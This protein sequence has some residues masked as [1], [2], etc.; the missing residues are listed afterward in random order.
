MARS[1]VR[2]LLDSLRRSEP[3]HCTRSSPGIG[4]TAVPCGGLP[5]SLGLWFS[6]FCA[7]LYVALQTD[8]AA[9]Q[10]RSTH[11]MIISPPSATTTYSGPM[12]IADF[13]GDGRPD[14]LTVS[15]K[16][17]VTILLQNADGTFTPKELPSVP[18]GRSTTADLN[19]DGRIDIV[20]VIDGPTGD[21]GEGLGPA[22][23]VISFARYDGTFVSEAPIDL[24]GSPQ[25]T[26][27][28]VEDVNH[29]G[30]PDI[31]T[32]ST[33]QYADAA[34]QSFLNTGGGHFR[35]GGT[36]TNLVAATLLASADFN[37]DGFLDLVVRND[38]GTLMLLGKGD[39]SFT[40]GA[41]FNKL[42]DYAAAG[43]LNRDGRQDLVLAT[44]ESTWVLLSKGDG[45]FSRRATLDTSFGTA[46]TDTFINPVEPNGVYVDD[47]NKDGILD[48][49]VTS[50]SL[51]RG[52]FRLLRKGQR[53]TLES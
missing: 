33:D 28:M 41:S 46:T 34:L 16:S 23:M 53:H 26:G 9:Q 43:D 49:L 42:S 47:L 21:H 10:F 12:A 27:V 50:S 44:T 25:A 2:H 40:A 22:T 11:R 24:S 51:Y 39:G 45:T 17:V 14:F 38:P 30:K 18:F 20:T 29:D 35:A 4:F 1:A 15:S 36:Y 19:G 5:W 13:D 37:G 7:V 52:G 8:A 3:T 32:V 6:P 31:I 48:V